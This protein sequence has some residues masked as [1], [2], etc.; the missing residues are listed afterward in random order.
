MIE[1]GEGVG[2]RDA[3]GDGAGR[4]VVICPPGRGDGRGACDAPEELIWAKADC[5]PPQKANTA[6]AMVIVKGIFI[7]FIVA[8][9][10]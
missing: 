7:I 10:I 9:Q 4:D 6:I 1:R 8:Q 3:P 2:R 5:S